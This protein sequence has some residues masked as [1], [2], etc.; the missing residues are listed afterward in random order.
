M[1]SL[2]KISGISEREI[3]LRTI[4]I[5]DGVPHSLHIFQWPVSSRSRSF[6]S[7]LKGIAVLEQKVRDFCQ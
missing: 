3:R 7:S 4:I 1:L 5:F 2:V 6:N